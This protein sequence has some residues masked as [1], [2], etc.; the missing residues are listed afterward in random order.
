MALDEKVQERIANLIHA[1][2]EGESE[3]YDEECEHDEVAE[4]YGLE[5][6]DVLLLLR[7]A[8]VS[9]GGQAKRT[10]PLYKDQEDRVFILAPIEGKVIKVIL[11]S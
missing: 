6:Y 1:L 8:E 2:P 7:K 9:W 11:T 5:V 10:L 3:P 4:E